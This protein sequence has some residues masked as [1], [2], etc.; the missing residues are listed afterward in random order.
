[1]QGTVHANAWLATVEP[2]AKIS[3]LH[4]SDLKTMQCFFSTFSC[5]I[6]IYTNLI[7][8]LLLHYSYHPVFA[9]SNLYLQV[10]MYSCM[11]YPVSAKCK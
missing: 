5:I 9:Y 10:Q 1:M 3:K 2:T 8:L 4:V 11:I 7:L 6:I